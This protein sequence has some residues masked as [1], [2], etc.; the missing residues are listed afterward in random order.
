[1][2]RDR[3]PRRPRPAGRLGRR[4][5]GRGRRR[6][7]ARGRVPGRARSRSAPGPN[8]EARARAARRAVLPPGSATGHTMDDQAETVFVNLLR[9]A[10]LDGLA[11]MRPGSEHPL[12]GAAPVP[13]PRPVRGARARA[14]ARPVQR[15]PPLRPQP[16]PPRAAPPGQRHRRARPRAR[17]R[18]P[19]RRSWP[20]RP[21][22]STTWRRGSTPPTPR[23]WPPRPAPLARRATRRWLRG[24]RPIPPTWPRWS[25]SWP[26]P[27]ARWAPP[28]SPRACG[29]GA[30]AG[31]CRRS[32]SPQER[33]VVSAPDDR[34]TRHGH[35]RRTR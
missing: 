5:R 3:R 6:R 33:P 14:G 23:R 24:R 7:P 26:W 1:M 15:R 18:P 22:C 28:T 2:C 35:T 21:S 4:G 9:G 29:C 13:D 11:G 8:L 17:A 20:T 31:R 30:R 27:G 16:R 32:R 34:G 12:L 25:G 10:G 19:G